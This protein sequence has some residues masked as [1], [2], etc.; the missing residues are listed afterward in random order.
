MPSFTVDDKISKIAEAYSL[1][2]VDMAARNFKTKLD[3]TDDSIAL[4]E[5]ILAKLH[6][7]L[8]SG[9]RPPED[10]I[11]TFAKAFGSY[12]G[13]VFRKNHGGDWGM[14]THDGQTFPGMRWKSDV[15][16]WPWGRV[17]QRIVA[18]VENNVLHYYQGMARG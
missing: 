5:G 16:F 11:W 9:Q 8:S 18:G 6:G 7:S 14:V 13:E 15:L 12:V 4:V 1:D 3:W 17:H 10:T 2:A